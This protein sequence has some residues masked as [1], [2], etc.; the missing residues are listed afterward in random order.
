M[1][2]NFYA[3]G[4][5]GCVVDKVVGGWQVGTKTTKVCLNGNCE[6]NATA[7]PFQF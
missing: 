5:A 4:V 1:A 6:W 7:V 2:I 3:G